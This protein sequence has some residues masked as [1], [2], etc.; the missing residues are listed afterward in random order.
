MFTRDSSIGRMHLHTNAI[1]ENPSFPPSISEALTTIVSTLE[2]LLSFP[3][4]PSNFPNHSGSSIPQEIS[5]LAVASR[6][7]VARFQSANNFTKVVFLLQNFFFT[8]YF[9]SLPF[10]RSIYYLYFTLFFLLNS[11]SLQV[12]DYRYFK[13]ILKLMIVEFSNTSCSSIAIHKS[14]NNYIII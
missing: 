9:I 8:L 6:S 10:L 5:M 2:H 7:N 3:P 12:V 14:L 4:I 13:L 11:Q 1:P